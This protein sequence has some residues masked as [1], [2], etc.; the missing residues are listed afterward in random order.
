[1]I[2]LANNFRGHVS[3]SSTCIISIVWFYFSWYSKV[4]DSKVATIINDKVLGFQIPM[5]DLLAVKVFETD[6]NAGQKEP[7]FFFF[8]LSAISKVI[9]QITS[10]TVIHD[11]IEVFPVLEGAGHV[12]QK[13]VGQ[14]LKKLF[15]IHHWMDW[16]LGNYLYLLHLLHS[17]N[18]IRTLLINLPDFP[19]TTLTNN[20]IQP[21][22]MK[23][24]LLRSF[25]LSVFSRVFA[26]GNSL[27]FEFLRVGTNLPWLPKTVEVDVSESA[28]KYRKLPTRSFLSFS[29]EE[30]F[31]PKLLLRVCLLV[32]SI[33]SESLVFRISLLRLEDLSSKVNWTGLTGWLVPKSVLSSKRGDSLLAYLIFLIP[34]NDI[35]KIMYSLT[36]KNII[37]RASFFLVKLSQFDLCDSMF[38]LRISKL[39]IF[40]ELILILTMILL[41]IIFWNLDE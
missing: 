40:Y 29:L 17:V 20:E 24:H 32:G 13:W 23:T 5:D 15:F 18:A 6:D 37:W 38:F 7:G 9:P 25:L 10:I 28:K 3:R 34:W 2:C 12:H 31:I 41:I 36:I 21:K 1:M 8:E 33:F 39:T 19:K 27:S 35:D 22:W 26:S 16:S 11:Q 30:E 4:S 14:F